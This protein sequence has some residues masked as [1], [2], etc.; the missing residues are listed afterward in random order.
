VLIC[1]IVYFIFT[2]QEIGIMKDFSTYQYNIRYLIHLIS[3]VTL[4][5][6]I[7]LFLSLRKELFTQ[8]VSILNGFDLIIVTIIC[9]M[10]I[11]RGFLQYQFPVYIGI[12]MLHAFLFYLSYKIMISLK[13]SLTKILFYGSFAISVS[14]L[15][16]QLLL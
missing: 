8:R 6:N 7:I 16:Y 9:L 1:W 11:L 5:I 13:P 15:L 3:L 2:T 12:D 10:F 4:S 14:A